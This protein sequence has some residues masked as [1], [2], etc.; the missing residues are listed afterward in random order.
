MSG[1]ISS[2]TVRIL[3]PVII[4][5]EIKAE[6]ICIENQDYSKTINFHQYILIK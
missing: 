5:A 4:S 3:K 1:D 6:V 2:L